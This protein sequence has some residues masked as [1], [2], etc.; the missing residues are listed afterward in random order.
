MVNAQSSNEFWTYFN[1]FSEDSLV[2]GAANYKQW[3]INGAI[4][5]PTLRIM[6]TGIWTLLHPFTF[7]HGSEFGT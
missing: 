6:P 5:V 7:V 2:I 4:A 3:T 1:P